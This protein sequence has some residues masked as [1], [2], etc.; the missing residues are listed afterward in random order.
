MNIILKKDAIESL[1]NFFSLPY[2]GVEQDWALEMANPDRL[3][4]FISHYKMENL[5][6]DKKIALMSLIV[7]SYD[8]LLDRNGLGSSIIWDE[9]KSI[10]ESEK[11]VFSSLIAYWSVY[12]EGNPENY[13]N[14]TPLMRTI[15]IPNL[16]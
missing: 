7:A 14:I 9:L 2:S 1:N 12:S 6:I 10:L 13:F 5:S 15:K 11:E 3:P 8:E 16:G 4:E